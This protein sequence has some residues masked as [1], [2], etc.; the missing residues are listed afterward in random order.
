MKRKTK[1][2]HRAESAWKCFVHCVDFPEFTA[3]RD[4]CV[5]IRGGNTVQIEGAKGIHTYE[6]EVVRV[7]MKRCLLAIYGS[8]F[9]LMH[10]ADGTLRVLGNLKN[11]CWEVE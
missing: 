1:R 6:R 2:K 10:F 7:H 8:D 3:G 9:E 11:L 4:E 5:E